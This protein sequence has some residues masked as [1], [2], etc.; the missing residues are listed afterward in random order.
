MSK[1]S[2]YLLVT[3]CLGGC[4]GDTLMHAQMTDLQKKLDDTQRRAAL[5]ERKAEDLQDQ[6]FLLTDKLESQKIAHTAAPRLPV[7][8]LKPEKADEPGS[9]DEIAFE[10]AAKSKDPE[11]TRPQLVLNGSPPRKFAAKAEGPALE[12]PASEKPAPTTVKAA[13]TTVAADDNLGVAPVP[14]IAGSKAPSITKTDEAVHLYKVGQDALR[15]GRHDEAAHSFRELVRRFPEHDLADNAQYWLGECFYA[16]K[17][18]LEA[19]P[20]FRQVVTRW[21]LGN[22]APDALLKL[23]FCA[24]SL[25]E[26]ERG[27]DLLRQLPISYPNTEA[28]RL[29]Q[30][31]LAEL[32]P[33]GGTQ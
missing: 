27:L 13:A 17:E 30:A 26:K 33:T 11:H 4:A 25:G 6:V 20:E 3:V 31:R 10:G 29:A 16:R 2:F 7:V 12:K 1:P 5:A 23:A 21:P 18:F 22:K 32:R 28:A 8:L 14:P 9:D 19:M 24:L 15:A